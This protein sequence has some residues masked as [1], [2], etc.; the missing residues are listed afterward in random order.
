MTANDIPK[1]VEHQ[2][3]RSGGSGRSHQDLIAANASAGLNRLAGFNVTAA[4]RRCRNRH[5]VERRSYP[6][7]RP[8]ACGNDC[9]SARYRVRFRGRHHCWRRNGNAFF[10]ELPEAGRRPALDREGHDR[11]SRAQTNLCKG[12]ALCRERSRREIARCDG[13]HVD[14]SCRALRQRHP[15]KAAMVRPR[16]IAESATGVADSA[17]LAL[18][19]E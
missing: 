7:C 12:R 19:S 14:G 15:L 8:S 16:R 18:A 11:S 10:D 1:G 5:G 2:G 6:V 3:K 17:M 4:E 13:R 9:G